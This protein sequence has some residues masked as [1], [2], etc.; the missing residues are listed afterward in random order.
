VAIEEEYRSYR[1]A[2]AGGIR[3]LRPHTEVVAIGLE[4]LAE[5]LARFHPHLVISSSPVTALI[6]NRIAWLE[7]SLD[8][9]QPS[10][11]SVIGRRSELR[12]PTLDVL[13]SVIDEVQELSKENEDPNNC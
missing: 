2:I 11:M 1:G 10:A 5:E 4:D 3:A 12:N 13:L 6:E 8:P 7:L 9:L